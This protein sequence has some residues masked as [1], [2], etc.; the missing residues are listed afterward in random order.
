MSHWYSS[1]SITSRKRET[2]SKHVVMVCAICVAT[3]SCAVHGAEPAG[4]A[5]FDL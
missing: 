4:R 2:R 1:N 3:L 5:P